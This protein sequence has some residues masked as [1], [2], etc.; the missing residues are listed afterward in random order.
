MV[1]TSPLKNFQKPGKCPF[2][3]LTTL[4]FDLKVAPKSFSTKLPMTKCS[5]KYIWMLFSN[6]LQKW[7]QLCQWKIYKKPQN[8][9]F[10]CSE[11]SFLS[12]RYLQNHL[13][14][15]FLWPNS[16]LKSV[17]HFASLSHK[18][19]S[20][21]SLNNLPKTKKCS[22]QVLRTFAFEL[23][24]STSSLKNLQKTEKCSFQTITTLV[25]ELKIA[26]KL[27]SRRLPLSKPWFK[28]LWMFCLSFP[29]NGFNFFNEKF[30][31]KNKK[32]CSFQALTTLVFE[33]KVAS[34]P[35]SKKLPMTKFWL[36]KFWTFCLTFPENGFNFVTQKF[37][38]NWTVHFSNA[39]NTRF[40]SQGSSKFI[41]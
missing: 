29:T 15:S 27:F 30:A 9:L 41:F 1:S 7:F 17:E 4:V 37:A 25:F 36:K 35:F 31:K 23:K 14:R 12:S 28:L 6:F 32:K 20:T 19:V 40:W 22:F 8:T 18:M 24:V 3:M 26:S 33:V 39:Y 13:L 34:K 21:S 5:L 16:D 11:H 10:K 2:Q 38:K